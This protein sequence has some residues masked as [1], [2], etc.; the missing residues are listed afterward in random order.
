MQFDSVPQLFF[1]CHRAAEEFIA[2]FPQHVN[3][4]RLVDAHVPLHIAAANNR[5][6]AVVLLARVVR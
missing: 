5:L 3:L 4:K 6:D 2:R 1:V